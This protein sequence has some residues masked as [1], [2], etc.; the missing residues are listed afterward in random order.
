MGNG[1]NRGMK[2]LTAQLQTMGYANSNGL[3]VPAQ[4]RSAMEA[5][6]AEEKRAREA[7]HMAEQLEREELEAERVRRTANEERQQEIKRIGEQFFVSEEEHTAAT[8]RWADKV[9]NL[10]TNTSAQKSN[11]ADLRAGYEVSKSRSKLC[12]RNTGPIK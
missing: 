1:Y 6:H 11:L 4:Q 2:S 8:E 7:A 5:R 3:T 10:V 12:T 9:A